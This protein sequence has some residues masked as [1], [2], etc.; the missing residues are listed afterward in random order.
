M[1]HLS[2]CCSKC[3]TEL[4]LI[5]DFFQRDKQKTTGFRPDCK[6]CN[7]KYNKDKRNKNPE[8]KKKRKEYNARPDVKE[9]MKQYSKEYYSRPGQ[10]EKHRERVRKSSALPENREHKRK[11]QNQ[12][13]KDDIQYRLSGNLR[14]RLYMAIKN[15]QKAGSAIDDLGCSI[16]Y[17]KKHLEKQFQPGMTWDNYGEWHIDHIRPLCSFDLTDRYYFIEAV[18][19]TNLQP[20]WAIDNLKKGER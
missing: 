6:A 3:H 4:P 11:Y 8:T 1:S 17:L 19:W 14:S 10:K 13:R 2:A 7:S 9:R 18:H 12:K 5:S 20:L 16:E 15:G